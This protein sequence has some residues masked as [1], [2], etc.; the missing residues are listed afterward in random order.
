MELAQGRV[1]LRILTKSKKKNEKRN[2]DRYL[3]R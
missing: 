2:K 3:D 1:H